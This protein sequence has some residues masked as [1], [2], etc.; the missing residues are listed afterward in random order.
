MRWRAGRS[1]ARCSRGG[2]AEGCGRGVG[3]P[4][5]LVEVAARLH[6][7]VVD[8]GVLGWVLDSPAP[9]A[10]A[11]SPQ[12]HALASSPAGG[13]AS[14]TAGAGEAD[15]T[16][17]D[18]PANP[19][20]APGVEL[21]S[22]SPA[23]E[24]GL[25]TR[26]AELSRRSLYSQGDAAQAN[27]VSL[28]ADG[29]GSLLRD[30]NRLIVNARVSST[31]AEVLAGIR[32]SG[33][34]IVSVNRRYG[35]IDLAVIPQDL[36]ALADAKGVEY[37]GET[38]LRRR[39]PPAAGRPASHPPRG[40]V[41]AGGGPASV[42]ARRKAT[43]SPVLP[44]PVRASASTETARPSGSSPTPSTPPRARALARASVSARATCRGRRTRVDTGPRSR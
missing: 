37:V 27:E 30:G 4:P 16:F 36:R 2:G 15:I 33:A 43:S 25:S 38:L 9:R 6:I 23:T 5:Q 19:G 29:L 24:A 28:P 14:S 7:R 42:A 31:S 41:R 13:I 12:L 11:R 32:A 21:P 40:A 22:S 44:L 20:F 8:E 1:C 18:L 35:T 17:G 39:P 34:E 26:L 10:R 3:E